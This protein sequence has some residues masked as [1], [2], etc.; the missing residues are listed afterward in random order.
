MPVVTALDVRRAVLGE[1]DLHLFNEGTA[2]PP[3]RACSAPIPARWPT[4]SRR[5]APSARER[6]RWSVLDVGDWHVDA[7]GR[8][9]VAV[10]RIWAASST[11]SGRRTATSC[12]STPLTARVR[13]QGRSVRRYAEVPPSHRR[14]R[15]ADLAYDWGDAD[16][17]A[18]SGAPRRLDAPMPHLRGAPRLVGPPACAP[19]AGSSPTTSWPSRSPSTRWPTASPTSS[20]CR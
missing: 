6:R 15:I 9:A 7:S 8:A 4:W 12:A 14:R 10:R 19:A 5:G 20:C 13:R 16:W 2:P 1:I 11:A 3:V 18:G 17:M